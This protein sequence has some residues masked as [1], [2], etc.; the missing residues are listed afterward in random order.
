RYKSTFQ[1]LISY[2]SCLDKRNKLNN[3][4]SVYELYVGYAYKDVHLAPTAEST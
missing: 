1:F 4:Q 3:H 2:L